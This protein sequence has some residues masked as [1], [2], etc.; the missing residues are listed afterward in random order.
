M[1]IDYHLEPICSTPEFYMLAKLHTADRPVIS[2]CNGPTERI[3]QFVDHFLNPSTQTLASFVK[4]TTHYL[5]ILD[6]RG[7]LPPNCLLASLDV[8]SLYTNID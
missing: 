4:D 3:S 1:V 8:S 6:N 7:T 5:Q 2:G